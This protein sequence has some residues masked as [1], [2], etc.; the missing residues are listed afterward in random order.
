LRRL[1]ARVCAL[2]L[3]A[4]VVTA[5]PQAGAATVVAVGSITALQSPGIALY[6]PVDGRLD[7]DGFALDVTGYR[8]A[9]QVGYGPS[10]QE[11]APEQALLVFG[12]SGTGPDVT[13]NLEVDGQGEALPS[14]TTS[15][16]STPS[17]FLASVPVDANDVALEL[18]ADGFSQTFSFTT[19]RR[20]GLQPAVLYRGQGRWQQV[21]NIGQVSYVETP[22]KVDGLMY[23]RVEVTLTA[24]TLTYFLPGTDATPTSPSKAW[25]VLSGSAMPN[26]APDNP[27]GMSEFLINYMKTLPGSDLTLTLPGQ[28]PMP[29]MLTGQG[30]SDDESGQN[31]G[32]GLFGGDY[33]WQVP[34]GIVSATLKVNLPAQLLAEGQDNGSPREIPVDGEVPPVRIAFA[35]PTGLPTVSSPNPPVWAGKAPATATV[36]HSR[37]RHASASGPTT[38]AKGDGS[39][40]TIFVIVVIVVI[41]FLVAAILFRRRRPVAAQVLVTD[42]R[43][44]QRP[45]TGG[46]SPSPPIGPAPAMAATASLR[47]TGPPGAAPPEPYSTPPPAVDPIGRARAAAP[48]PVIKSDPPPPPK[49]VLVPVPAGPPPRPVGMIEAV[50][51]DGPGVA[52]RP[53]GVQDLDASA[54]ELLHFLVANEGRAFTGDELRAMISEGRPAELGKKTMWTYASSLRQAIGEQHLPSS[55]GRH[56]LVG[57]TSDATRFNAAVARS[58][59]DLANTAA[60]LTEALSFVSGVPYVHAPAG[61]Y[62][63]A[64]LGDHVSSLSNTVLRVAAGLSRLALAAGDP[65]LAS[66]A[67]AKGRLIRREDDRLLRLALE[68]AAISSEL[69]DLDL[70]WSAITG[71][72]DAQ[73][74]PVPD[75]L[76]EHYRR[77]RQQRGPSAA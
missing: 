73:K 62:G 37:A 55:T 43:Q 21:D 54:M 47:P 26:L 70:T 12:L 23:D 63:W 36:A 1:S 48:P 42:A 34:A 40:G 77:L 11:A 59:S 25:V 10:V 68:A 3:S 17:Y 29:A 16:A 71:Q 41:A 24:A 46:F 38:K 32:W 51:F 2:V 31:G 75:E 64:Q 4:V 56:R 69:S 35:P 52:G 76:A 13:A 44:A 60:H 50:V 22:D 74:E 33:Y 6:S 19:G 39:P 15:N 18:S 27:G 53:D 58:K 61:A 67:V 30:G 20:E 28:K 9:Y 8:F 45:E 57:V 65:E 14:A 72:F 7:G 66:W 49:P 5:M